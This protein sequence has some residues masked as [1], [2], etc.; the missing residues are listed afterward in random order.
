MDIVLTLRSLDV[1]SVLPEATVT[2]SG[3]AMTGVL[4]L[5]AELTPQYPFVGNTT[6][7]QAAAAE[8]KSILCCQ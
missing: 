6:V 2:V 1:K 5:D 7:S 3:V 4:R 8:E